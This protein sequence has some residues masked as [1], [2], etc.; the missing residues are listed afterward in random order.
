MSFLLLVASL[1]LAPA[2]VNK[3]VLLDPGSG[4][5]NGRVAIMV[6]PGRAAKGNVEP[7]PADDCQ[8]HMVLVDDQTQES[9]YPCGK[10]FQP[11]APGRYLEWVEQKRFIS[12]Q[13]VTVYGG[14]AF[15]GSGLIVVEPMMPAARVALSTT[16]P[17]AAGETFRIISLSQRE[18]ARLFD[19]RVSAAKVRSKTFALPAG[20]VIGGIFDAA[21]RALLLSRPVHLIGP[22]PTV[23]TPVPATRGGDVLVVLE[24]DDLNAMRDPTTCKVLLLTEQR[25]APAVDLRSHDRMVS[26]W[27]GIRS[28]KAAV[29]LQCGKRQIDRAVTIRNEQVVT[30]RQRIQ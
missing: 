14:E 21:G 4:E 20:R 8:V 27:Y 6:W 26:V 18:R 16:T 10:W 15:R 25:N 19:R 9:V 1:L 29:R 28:G 7:Q 17:V 13:R 11:A 24:G 12:Y 23:V 22:E 5:I 30:F 3:V 2:G